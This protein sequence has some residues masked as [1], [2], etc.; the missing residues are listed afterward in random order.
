MEDGGVCLVVFFFNDPVTPEIYTLSL[1]DVFR[2]SWKSDD[3]KSA[4]GNSLGGRGGTGG[5]GMAIHS[6][7]K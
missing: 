5:V 2:S 7:H 1:H 3:R 4:T 6:R